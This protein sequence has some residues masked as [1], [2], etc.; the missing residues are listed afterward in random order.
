MLDQLHEGI[1]PGETTWP[2][3]GEFGFQSFVSR[4]FGHMGWY[5]AYRER[6]LVQVIPNAAF[7]IWSRETSRM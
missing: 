2:R 1:I 6:V 7:L 3:R 5:V 4:S